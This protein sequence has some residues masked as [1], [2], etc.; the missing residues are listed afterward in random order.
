VRSSDLATDTPCH[1]PRIPRL[2]PV[3]HEVPRALSTHDAPTAA[4]FQTRSAFHRWIP[5]APPLAGAEGATSGPPLMPRLSRLG[6]AS[7]TRSPT[8]L[9]A[10]SS[11]LAGYS[12]ER[13]GHVPSI[14]F[15]NCQD[16]RARPRTAQTPP[17]VRGGK[18]PHGG[19]CR[20]CETP[21]AEL[22]QPRGQPPPK[23]ASNARHDVRYAAPDLPQP[24]MPQ[25]PP[26]T[27]QHPP[28]LR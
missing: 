6:P 24:V 27:H 9:R 1:T 12:P 2:S 11:R 4:A 28:P 22:L 20:S 3:A 21:P 26:V 14:D 18:P 8:S 19:W 10:R 5:S 16:S 7:D 13:L 17:F 23:E 25:T 15:C